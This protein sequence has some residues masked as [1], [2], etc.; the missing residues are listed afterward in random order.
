[1]SPAVQSALSS[2]SFRPGILLAAILVAVLYFRGWRVLHRVA[3]SRFPA[4]RLWAF[5]A[6]LLA[7]LI[8]LVSP[9][10]TFSGLLLSAHMVQHL[11]LMSVAPPL[12]LLGAPFLPLLRGLPR[13]FARDGLGPFLVWPSLRRF[14][15]AL[16]HP[17]VGWLALVVSLCAWHVP[18][19]FDLA[20]RS[21]A[22]HK[23]EHA[24]FFGGALLF[25]WPIIQPFPS[26]SHW[27]LWSIP[28]YLLAA[29]IVN[30]VLCAFLTFSVRV[31]YLSYENVPR[32]FGTTALSDQVTAGVIMWVPGSLAFLIP[33]VVV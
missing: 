16:T 26:R 1:M 5:L 23:V 12:I 22:W 27:P 14:G 11:I 19:A 30:T 25:W 17:I 33:A 31:L 3:P 20:L 8:A 10:D 32:L 6:G 28:L 4:W 29:D 13:T 9:L 2:W 7:L 24:C 15:W 18:A 21:A